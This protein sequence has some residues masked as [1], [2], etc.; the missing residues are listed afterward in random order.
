M[1]LAVGL[2]PID[3]ELEV[4]FPPIS[5]EGD[6]HLFTCMDELAMLLEIRP[7]HARHHLRVDLHSEISKLGYRRSFVS[8]IHSNEMAE[9]DVREVSFPGHFSSG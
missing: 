2:E 1:S 3:L 7:V 9:G 5:L 8:V 6:D 4:F